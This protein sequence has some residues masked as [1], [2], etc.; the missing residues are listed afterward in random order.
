MLLS[1]VALRLS[2][3]NTIAL[4]SHSLAAAV[5]QNARKRP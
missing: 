2:A 3:N 5:A 4:T 1:E